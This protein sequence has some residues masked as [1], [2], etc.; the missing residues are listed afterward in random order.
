[1]P[2]INWFGNRSLRK[3]AA[4]GHARAQELIDKLSGFGR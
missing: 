2:L 4:Q 1:M 3:A